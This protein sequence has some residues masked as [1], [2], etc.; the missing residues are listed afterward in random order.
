MPEDLDTVLAE[1]LSA[2]E[3]GKYRIHSCGL[4][5]LN[6]FQVVATVKISMF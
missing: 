3:F 2:S 5:L 6:S 4:G 1:L